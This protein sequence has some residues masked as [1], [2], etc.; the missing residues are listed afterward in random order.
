MQ[1]NIELQATTASRA[2]DAPCILGPQ[3]RK[4]VTILAG[5][6]DPNQ[7]EEVRLLLHNGNRVNIYGAQVINLGI[8]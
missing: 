7:Q 3:E 8:S 4:A 5:V 1:L 6:V 2:L